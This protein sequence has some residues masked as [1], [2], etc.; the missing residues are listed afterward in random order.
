M[1][2]LKTKEN[3]AD[4]GA[5]LDTVDEK[6]RGDCQH[7]RALME[8]M[9]G[10]PARM[11]GKN[12]VGFGHYQYRYA[13]GREGEWFR[14]GFAPRKQDLTL[15]VMDGYEGREEMLGRLGKHRTGKSCLYIKRLSDIDESVLREL[16]T[17]SLASLAEK[18]PA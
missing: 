2:E 12:I 17:D 16:I 14:I 18:Y 3:D 7:L 15:Y 1:A 5:F 8:E 9:T 6:R 11:W 10:E 13:S 4:V